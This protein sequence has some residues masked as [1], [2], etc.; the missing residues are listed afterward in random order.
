MGKTSEEGSMTEYRG[1]FTVVVTP[2]RERDEAFDEDAMR[3]FVDWQVA[4][5]AHGLVTLGSMGEFFLVDDDER[6]RIIST[7]VD[8]AAGRV[9]V[10]AGTAN[11][12]TE[13]AVG[14]SREAE[15]LGADGIMVLPPLYIAPTDAEIVAYFRR[16]AEAVSIPIMIYN[17]PTNASVDIPAEVVA[18]LAGEFDNIRYIKEASGEL[19]RVADIRRLAGETMHVWQGAHP[20]DAIALG[21]EGWVS[22]EGN[23]LPRLSAQMFE[24]AQGGDHAGSAAIWTKLLAVNTAIMAGRPARLRNHLAH[25]IAIT[26]EL[27]RLVGQPM[28]VPRAPITRFADYTGADAGRI[29]PLKRMLAEL[30]ALA[31]DEAA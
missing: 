30:G 5:G 15:E 11:A 13:K 18:R 1:S 10:F 28:G 24:L 9:P 14:F 20:F 3:R 12:R 8:Q 29:E 16:I 25:I 31:R 2:F 4:E 6:G 17:N 21:G 23:F 22:P 19:A 7:V 27:C 26:K